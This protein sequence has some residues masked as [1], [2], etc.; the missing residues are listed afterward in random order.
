MIRKGVKHRPP[1]K[2]VVL[3]RGTAFGRGDQFWQPKV[4]W[5]DQIWQLKVVWVDHYWLQKVITAKRT[6]LL[7]S[8]VTSVAIR[9]HTKTSMCILFLGDTVLTSMEMLDDKQGDS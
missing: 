6:G 9:K 7:L 4:V 3:K 5:G 8:L 2:A 1:Q